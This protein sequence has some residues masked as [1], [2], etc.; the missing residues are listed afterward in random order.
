MAKQLNAF[1]SYSHVDTLALERLTKHLAMLRRDRIISEWFDQR[2][3]AGGERVR[4]I[5]RAADRRFPRLPLLL[6]A[7]DEAL[8]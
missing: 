8:A 7:R 2:I 4:S 6:R 1:I 3:T 5:H